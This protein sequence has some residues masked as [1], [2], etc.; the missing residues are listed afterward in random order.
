MCNKALKWALE[1]GKAWHACLYTIL[2]TDVSLACC[3]SNFKY[4]S[5]NL[6]FLLLRVT[7]RCMMPLAESISLLS[8]SSIYLAISQISTLFEWNCRAFVVALLN[9]RSDLDLIQKLMNSFQTPKSDLNWVVNLWNRL[10]MRRI[11]ARSE[12]A[13]LRLSSRFLST[14]LSSNVNSYWIAAKKWCFRGT[15][16]TSLYSRAL[17]FSIISLTCSSVN[18]SRSM[19]FIKSGTMSSRTPWTISAILTNIKLPK[20]HPWTSTRGCAYFDTRFGG[21]FSLVF[22][23]FFL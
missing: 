12:L 7:A 2:G 20:R 21:Q 5:H 3:S 19:K 15:R 6:S 11:I 9:C 1:R 14:R 13:G 17:R 16:L 4:S 18:I 10:M 22:F 8:F 23:F